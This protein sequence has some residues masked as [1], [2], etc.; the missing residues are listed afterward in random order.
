MKSTHVRRPSLA[1]V[2][3]GA[4]VVLLGTAC[5][6]APKSGASKAASST[7]TPPVATLPPVP[8]NG[9][10]P[11]AEVG[12][13]EA[14]PWPEAL[15]DALH[16]GA[17]LASG[18]TTGAIRWARNLGAPVVGGPVVGSDGTIYEAANNGV[19]HALDPATGADRWTFN[20]GG[21]GDNGQD[22]STSAAILSDGTVVWPG[23]NS[24]LYGLDPAGNVLWQQTL[25][26]AVLSPALGPNGTLYVADTKG[27]V[28]A[29]RANAA[30]AQQMWIISIGAT[31][32][33]SP[34]IAPDG[35][36]YG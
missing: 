36:I 21:S 22:L 33:G 26:G 13:P 15:H 14:T 16:R 31:S 5:G 20:G 25:A 28:A 24:S 30:G 32:F 10:A 3:A 8:P 7:S 1:L 6:T 34:A 12:T 9:A 29:Y 35:T 4:A 11:T 19:L 2:A 17:S 23:P 27:D 18:P